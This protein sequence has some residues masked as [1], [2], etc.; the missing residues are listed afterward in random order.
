MLYQF[1]LE[2]TVA[3]WDAVLRR[4]LKHGQMR[5][6]AS[7]L[8][9]RLHSRG[10]SPDHADALAG[11]GNGLLRPAAGVVA[12]ASE[13]VEPGEVGLVRRREGADGA[14]QKL[15]RN[16]LAG[17]G[18]DRPALR[19]FVVMRVAHPGL[20]LDVPAPVKPIGDMLEVRQYLGLAWLGLGPVP[21]L[22]KL[23]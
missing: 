20:K 10:A 22:H 5:R 18:L 23:F 9:N 19:R 17:A 15:R 1:R 21:L 16:A 13:I 6:L 3:S 8:G 12:L 2:R 7:D 4:T 14:D 11:K